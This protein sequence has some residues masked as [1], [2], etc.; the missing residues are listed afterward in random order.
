MYVIYY[1]TVMP[2]YSLFVLKVLLH[3]SK[4]TTLKFSLRT[5]GGCWFQKKFTGW[6]PFVLPNQQC[7]IFIARQ[8]AMYAER[9]VLANPPVCLSVC[10]FV[11][12]SVCLS[13][14]PITL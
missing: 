11:C 8:H 1:P 10:L 13:V 5:F 7:P 12:L 9:D 2:R 3:P 4:Q 14:C 6:M